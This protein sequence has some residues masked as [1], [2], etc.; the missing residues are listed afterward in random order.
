M[1]N[2]EQSWWRHYFPGSVSNP[3]GLVYRLIKS[4]NPAARSAITMAAAG[5]VLTPIDLLLRG[6][7]RR[8]YAES[9]ESGKTIL[10]VVGA[11]RSGTT[12]LAQFLINSL[13]VCYINNLTSLFPRSPITINRILRRF[14]PL[15]GG[16]YSAFYGKSR[17]LS[18]A[19]D[20]LYIW[21]RWLGADRKNVPSELVPL[22][23]ESMRRFFRALTNL[24]RLPVVN[25]LN[26]LN[27]CA[28]LVSKEL[29]QVRFLCLH[30][31][32]LFLAQSLYIARQEIAGDM[33]AAYGV[34]H[35]DTVSDDAVEDVCQQ[36][37]F[38]E[39]HARQQQ[40]ILGSRQFSIVSYEEFCRRPGD[41]LASLVGEDPDLKIKPD[42]QPE[43][44]FFTVSDKAKIPESE[45]KRMRLR[46]KELG[47]G[48]VNC[49]SF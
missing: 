28:H 17:G 45:F 33:N 19:N 6:A 29:K 21:D 22:S 25:K 1:S 2:P 7:E 23:G 47:A 5:A 26:R 38:H 30:R 46:L 12:L 44:V 41:L 49:R 43:S 3:F 31:N 9:E 16:D 42:F 24:Y 11:P 18:G 27:T 13:D 14:V 10:L 35:S 36:V 20:A 40:K 34:R 37:L 4:E 39:N 15:Q 32:P 48:G 8:E